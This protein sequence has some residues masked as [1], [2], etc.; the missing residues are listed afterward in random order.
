MMI[1]PRFPPG[2]ILFH[3]LSTEAKQQLVGAAVRLQ[4]GRLA[5]PPRQM[6]R[7]HPHLICIF[8]TDGVPQVRVCRDWQDV[9]TLQSYPRFDDL[10]PEWF[11]IGDWHAT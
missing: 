2:N 6:S 1:T 10:S 11:A 3:E 8:V 7:K 5:E 4:Y 9:L